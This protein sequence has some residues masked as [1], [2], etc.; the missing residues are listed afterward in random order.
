MIYSTFLTGKMN[1]KT[2]FGME[3]NSFHEQFI[4]PGDTDNLN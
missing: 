2:E 1:D 4:R 3:M